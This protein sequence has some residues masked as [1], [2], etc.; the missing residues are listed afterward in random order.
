[1]R[2]LSL[3][4][5]PKYLVSDDGSLG[6]RNDVVLAG[7][8]H[9]MGYRG[10]VNAVLSFG[11][12]E[13]TSGTPG[14]IGWLVGEEN[15]G[16]EYMFHMMNEARI[17]VGASAAAVGYTS[18]LTALDYART[19]LQGRLVDNKDLAAPQV[20]IVEHPDVRRMLLTSKSYVE[21][22]LALVLYLA[23]QQDLHLVAATSDEGD[24]TLLLLDILTPVVKGWSSKWSLVANDYA[25]QIHG[26]Y[27]YTR[28]YSVEQ[29]WRDNRLNPIHEGTD[30][31]QA[32]DLIGRKTSM[33][34]GA[35]LTA[36]TQEIRTTIKRGL[37][38]TAELQKH[39]AT[40]E[41][42][43]S[44]LEAVTANIHA[45]ELASDR[46]A[47]ASLY[48]DALGH[49]VIGWMWLEQLLACAGK[50]GAFYEGKRAASHYFYTFELAQCDSWLSIL[51]TNP[52]IYR[53]TDPAS[54]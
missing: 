35:A 9:K 31:I 42:L 39:A 50:T 48:A 29:M 19:R 28:D 22:A 3:F 5:V 38:G 52:N 46:I 43:V 15:R 18:Y 7:I 49:I 47:N 45:Q 51:A 20:P 4:I 30:G 11:G 21:G 34:N 8:N 44:K 24:R 13:N 41:S 53:D 1:V 12:S 36:L 16:L 26:G 40:L 33:Q 32:I 37:A 23:K 6:E 17:V 14:A 25:I 2:G 10:T 54:L 27:G